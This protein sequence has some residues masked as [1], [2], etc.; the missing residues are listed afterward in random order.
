MQPDH[1]WSFA[2]R[3]VDLQVAPGAENK[4]GFKNAFAFPPG[5]LRVVALSPA[6]AAVFEGPYIFSNKNELQAKII[7][8][9]VT[10]DPDPIEFVTGARLPE[11]F[12]QAG[13]LRLAMHLALSLGKQ[14]DY[15]AIQRE[16]FYALM[17]A[18]GQDAG[19]T[20]VPQR[21]LERWDE[22]R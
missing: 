19:D 4:T 2:I 7:Q 20:E 22:V 12:L 1:R 16:Y 6:G 9:L 14:K 17:Q 10:A 11:L 13:A 5:A 3:R 18:K 21:G 8:S 15:V